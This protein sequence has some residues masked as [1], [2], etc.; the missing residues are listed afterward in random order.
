MTKPSTAH[1]AAA[2]ADRQQ[3]AGEVPAQ[4]GVDGGQ[5]LPVAGG[6]ED[7]PARPG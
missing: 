7:A 2:A 5:Q 3:A 1:I 6:V 4:R